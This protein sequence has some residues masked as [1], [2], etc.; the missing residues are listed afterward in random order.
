MAKSMAYPSPCRRG[1]T[2]DGQALTGGC[3]LP[4]G[5]SLPRR[6][7]LL[8]HVQLPAR[9]GLLL[10][11]MLLLLVFCAILANWNVKSPVKQAGNVL[12]DDCSCSNLNNTSADRRVSLSAAPVKT[13]VDTGSMVLQTARPARL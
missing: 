8:P 12:P 4:G 13:A 10:L 6:T 11:A 5:Y 3:A 9:P 2:M 1:V 7:D